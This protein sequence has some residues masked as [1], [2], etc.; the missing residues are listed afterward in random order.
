MP[1][2]PHR[3]TGQRLSPAEMLERLVAFPTVSSETN[4][5]LIAF[6]ED[7]LA[8]HGVPSTRVPSPCGEKASLFATIGPQVEGGV[9]LSGHTDVVPAREEGWT[10]DPFRLARRAGRLFGRGTADMK[11]FD[12]LALA[13]VPDMVAARLNAPI[14]IALSYDEEVGCKGAPDLVAAMV[15]AIA[16]PRAVIVG[17]PTMMRPVVGHKASF[18]FHAEVTGRACHSSRIDLGVSA[19]TTAARLVAWLDDRMADNRAAADPACPFAPPWTTVH[20]GMIEGG[21]APNVVAAHCRFVCDVRALPG[22]EPKAVLDRFERHVREDVEPAMKAVAPEAGVR[23]VPRS[24]VPGLEPEEDGEA[25]RLVRA[26]TGAIGGDVVSY[27]TEAGIFQAAG[28]SCVVCGPGD[29]G[30]AHQAN[31]CLEETQLAAGERFMARLIESL[32]A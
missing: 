25:A 3:P 16:P 7:Y 11:G 18:S 21:V 4:L 13:A 22:D 6:V 19:V 32:S 12:A 5:P 14:H 31:E 26:L 10:T 8:S 9:V 30:V 23:I 29:I 20:V 27:G 24:N 2:T 28:W 17:E 15:D 1:D